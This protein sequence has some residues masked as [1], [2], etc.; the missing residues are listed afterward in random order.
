MNTIIDYTNFTAEELRE[1]VE[2]LKRERAEVMHRITE[3]DCDLR[4]AQ[5]ELSKR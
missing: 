5:K 1:E 3:I 4:T 2:W